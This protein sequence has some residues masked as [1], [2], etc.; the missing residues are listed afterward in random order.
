MEEEKK[1][2]ESEFSSALYMIFGHCGWIES[3]L[4]SLSRLYSR[5]IGSRVKSGRFKAQ[6]R[7]KFPTERLKVESEPQQTLDERDGEENKSRL[8]DTNISFGKY[9]QL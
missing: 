2:A 1:I 3:R 7:Y 6:R 5:R 8:M 4:D 9:L